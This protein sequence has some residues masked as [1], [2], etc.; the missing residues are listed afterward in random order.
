MRCHYAGINGIE[1]CSAIKPKFPKSH[2]PLFSGQAVTTQQRPRK[3]FELGICCLNLM[4][5]NN[6]SHG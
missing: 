5:Q 4:I 3:K 6:R 1:V 2:I